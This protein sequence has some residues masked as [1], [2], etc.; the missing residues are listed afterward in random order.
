MEKKKKV[1]IA[2]PTFYERIHHL[3]V[4]TL[5]VGMNHLIQNGYQMHYISVPHMKLTLARNIAVAKFLSQ[6]GDYIIFID[7]DMVPSPQN[8]IQLVKYS[9]KFPVISGIY[10]RRGSQDNMD[11]RYQYTHMP[12]DEDDG[13]DVQKVRYVG[14]GIVRIHRSVFEEIE[15]NEENGIF[16][17]PHPSVS[18]EEYPYLK[19]YFNT[20]FDEKKGLVGEDVDFSQKCLRS[21]IDLYID[22]TIDVGHAMEITR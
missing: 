14:G 7:D 13:S 6:G 9:S 10:K 21:G 3:Q 4:Q 8:L 22:K 16:S 17:F 11:S 1:Y 18:V 12:E 15:K 2:T 19:T 20:H 5:I